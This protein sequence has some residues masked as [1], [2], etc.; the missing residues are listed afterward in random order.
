MAPFPNP[1]VG[2]E[3][4]NERQGKRKITHQMS[5]T[6]ICFHV[7]NLQNQIRVFY[8]PKTNNRFSS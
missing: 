2:L 3:M 6:N 8:D 4:E 7:W 5:D 1:F